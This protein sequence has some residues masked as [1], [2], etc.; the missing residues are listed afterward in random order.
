MTFTAA[1]MLSRWEPGLHMPKRR[2]NGAPYVR[3]NLAKLIAAHGGIELLIAK[4]AQ[5]GF[6]QLSYGQVS[7]WRLRHQVP[8]DKLLEIL[9][10]LQQTKGELNIWDYV[11][12]GTLGEE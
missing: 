8:S 11:T 10:V 4:H 9:Y 12:V 7:N 2:A 1:T 3:W 6:G 5:L